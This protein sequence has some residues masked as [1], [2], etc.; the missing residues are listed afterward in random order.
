MV[1]SDEDKLEIRTLI[2]MELML[3]TIELKKELKISSY[4]LEIQNQ[5]RVI[6]QIVENVSR[7]R[8]S[9]LTATRR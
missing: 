2:S 7:K 1:F 8:L 3:H 4:P 5:I 6:C 9:D